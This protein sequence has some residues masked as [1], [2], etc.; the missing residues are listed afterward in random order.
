VKEKLSVPVNN[1]NLLLSEKLRHLS[2]RERK[3]EVITTLREIFS[4]INHSP[5][6]L[7]NTELLFSKALEQDP[8]R[9]FQL[10][11]RDKLIITAWNGVV[12]DEQLKYAEFGH[13]EYR[14]YDT[15]ELLII[16]KEY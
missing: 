6:L 15:K 1:L 16:S 9:V 12:K 8:I 5:V 2:P 3:T 10:L 4:D 14:T 11:S 13:P 7:D